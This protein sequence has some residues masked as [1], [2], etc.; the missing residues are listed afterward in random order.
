[1]LLLTN[2]MKQF[3]LRILLYSLLFHLGVTSHFRGGTISWR[4]VDPQNFNGLVN[5][6]A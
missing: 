1:M 6:V 5:L 4:P 2:R 3:G